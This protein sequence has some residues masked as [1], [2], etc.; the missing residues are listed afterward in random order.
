MKAAAFPLLAIA[1]LGA[2][3]GPATKTAAGIVVA[4]DQAS[5]T[6]IRSFT[7]RT[8]EG[9]LLTFVV[10]ELDISPGGFPANHLREHMATSIAVAVAYEEDGDELVATRLAD[11]TWLQP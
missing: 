11:A 8:P 5:L 1:V 3:C 9:E 2:G 4:V 10:G 6:D 7:L